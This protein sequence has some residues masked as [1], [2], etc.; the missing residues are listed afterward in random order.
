MVSEIGPAANDSS[1]I[2]AS[3]TVQNIIRLAARNDELYAAL[4]H[5]IRVGWPDDSRSIPSEL[6][7]F[8]T[9]CDELAVEGDFIFKGTRLFVPESARQEMINR[10]HSSHIGVNACIRRAAEAIFWPGMTAEIANH[11]RKCETCERYQ[12]DQQKEPLISHEIPSRP[13]QVVGCDLM[14]YNQQ[15]YLVTV[16]YLSNYFEIDRLDSKKAYDVIYRL[17]QHF[18]RHGLVEKVCQ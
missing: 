7:V 15:A 5:Q 1:A 9:F 8:H 6:R 3:P 18:A 16:D 11:I 4:K 13:W 14:E 17:K 2:V 12:S 10:S